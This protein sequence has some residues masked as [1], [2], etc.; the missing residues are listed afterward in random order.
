MYSQ[1][2]IDN[3]ILDSF[4][5]NG[6]F[7]EV[8]G[9][10]PTDQNNTYLLELN[11]WTGL[12]I[13][14][15]TEYNELYKS[16]RPNTILENTCVVD[17]NHNEDFVWMDINH[18]MMSGIG[19]GDN[20]KFSVSPDIPTENWHPVKVNCST[21]DNL[22]TKHNINEIHFL[23]LDIEGQEDKAI[24]G[25][26]FSKVFIHCI[27]VEL[28]YKFDINSNTYDRQTFTNFDYLQN[29]NFIKYQQIN[30][31]C[32]YINKSSNYTLKF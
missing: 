32:F 28:H 17:F 8:G 31:H 3:L 30:Q 16:I 26:D 1:N 11:G 29:F 18:G 6:V 4:G 10:H 20:G 5:K 9:S 19:F 25:I 2:N 21:L 22:F 12:S 23:S 24:N 15:R 13:E 27:V 14:P 7:V